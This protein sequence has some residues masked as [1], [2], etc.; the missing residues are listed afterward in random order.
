MTISEYFILTKDAEK[1]VDGFLGKP[2][3]L[4]EIMSEIAQFVPD[5]DIV[6]AFKIALQIQRNQV[7]SCAFEV[8]E[9]SECNILNEIKNRIAVLED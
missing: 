9:H 5:M 1:V 7:L 4:S 8:E 3:Y 2:Q 6:D